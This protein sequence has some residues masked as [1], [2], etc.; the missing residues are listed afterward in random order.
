MCNGNLSLNEMERMFLYNQ[1]SSVCVSFNSHMFRY[2][3]LFFIF[4]SLT[5]KK[6]VRLVFKVGIPI[7]ILNK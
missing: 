6:Y 7:I 1:N 2:F 5:A 4:L 3:Y